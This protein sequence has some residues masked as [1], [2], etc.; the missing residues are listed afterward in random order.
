MFKNTDF[1]L[2]LCSLS[3][4]NAPQ[5]VAFSKKSHPLCTSLP[6]SGRKWISRN[7]A[8]RGESARYLPTTVSGQ[9]QRPGRG[10]S[11]IESI[12]FGQ[13]IKCIIA[14]LLDWMVPSDRCKEVIYRIRL[15]TTENGEW[16]YRHVNLAKKNKIKQ[17]ACNKWGNSWNMGR[18]PSVWEGD[19]AAKIFAR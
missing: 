4:N 3:L 11:I 10:E 2:P 16:T 18:Y 9:G 7:Q 1:P 14:Y 6:S 19:S 17:L 12:M 5:A 15:Q 8:T 13:N